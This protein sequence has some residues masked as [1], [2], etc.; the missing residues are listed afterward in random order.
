M[1]GYKTGGDW[2]DVTSIGR[3]EVVFEGRH[4]AYGAFYIRKRY[5]NA[6]YFSFLSAITF[7]AI[8]AYVP[9]AMRN[10][11]HVRAAAKPDVII[12][13]TDVLIHTDIIIPQIKHPAV[14]PPR[15]NP[16]QHM[17]PVITRQPIDSDPKP[18][19]EQP[20]P[21]PNPVNPLPGGPPD[22]GN[23]GPGGPPPPLPPVEKTFMWV[24][25]M[26]KFP[27]GD[28]ETYIGEKIK[29]SEEDIKLGIEGTVH[30]TFIIEKDGSV[31][32]VKLLRG[33]AGGS[34]L[35][36]E[37]LR[38]LSEMPKWTPGKQDGHPVR[39]QFSIPIQF[40]LR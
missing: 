38:V 14:K 24:A 19:V 35:D 26:P 32:N 10:I 4:K 34:D 12:K 16:N 20:L 5:P 7:V 13:P 28:V 2:T 18:I 15:I 37:A 8:C 40:K 1:N 31:S 21:N 22:I 3:N 17:P 6:L 11:S 36:K 30:A 27:G 23:P 29:Y 25:E 9:Y 39:V 33:I